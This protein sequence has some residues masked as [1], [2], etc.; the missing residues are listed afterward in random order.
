MS[1]AELDYYQILGVAKTASK[2]DI[3]KAYLFDDIV[4]NNW[5]LNTI[6]VSS[7]ITRMNHTKSSV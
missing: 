7:M 2:I 6:L 5:R 4:T 1:K 3:C